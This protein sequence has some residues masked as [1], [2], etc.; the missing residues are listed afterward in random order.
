MFND[1]IYTV[2]NTSEHSLHGGN[3]CG[4]GSLVICDECD[5]VKP[6]QESTPVKPDYVEG[7]NDWP[8]LSH[9]E[10]ITLTQYPEWR[11]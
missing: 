6:V 1:Y 2:W 7:M 11:A 8:Y 5:K 4:D 10:A 3:V 9:E